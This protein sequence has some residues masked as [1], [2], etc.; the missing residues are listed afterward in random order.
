MDSEDLTEIEGAGRRCSV[1]H[2]GR[3]WRRLEV[4]RPTDREPVVLCPS[5][6][7][8]VGD[9]LAAEPAAEPTPAAPRAVAPRAT[10]RNA[11]SRNVTAKNVTAKTATAKTATANTATANT[12][13][14]KTAAAKTR[15]PSTPNPGER[16][17][18]PRPD[19]LRTALA[20]MTGSFSTAMAARAAGIN[21][22]KALARLQDLERQGEVHRV[23]NRWS[24]QSP[25]SDVAAAIDRLEARTSNLRIIREPARIG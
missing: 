13:T 1:C 11:T 6:R 22:D 4:V 23:G 3:G 9:K 18:E 7:A 24:T 17:S 8:R 14:A 20:E 5:C 19:R 15:S 25:P 21:N 12:A 2:S 16:Q 10:S